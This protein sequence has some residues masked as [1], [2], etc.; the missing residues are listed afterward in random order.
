MKILDLRR[1]ME[2]WSL[3]DIA[4]TC[5]SQSAFYSHRRFPRP[6]FWTHYTLP[7]DLKSFEGDPLCWFCPEYSIQR[8]QEDA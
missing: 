6:M 4:H 3:P 7:D 2:S 1:V 8:S 5:P